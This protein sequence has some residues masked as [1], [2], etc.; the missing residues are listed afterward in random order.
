MLPGSWG[1]VPV[2]RNPGKHLGLAEETT[3]LDLLRKVSTRG[4][5]WPG[6][7]KSGDLCLDCCR[8]PIPDEWKEMDG[9][10]WWE[11][12]VGSFLSELITFL[13]S[14]WDLSSFFCYLSYIINAWTLETNHKHPLFA[15]LPY[16]A[17]V[18]AHLCTNSTREILSMCWY[19]CTSMCMW[20]VFVLWTCWH[21]CMWKYLE[22]TGIFITFECVWTGP[23]PLEKYCLSSLT[24]L[25]LLLFWSKKIK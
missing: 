23:A 8:D 7:G 4:G 12:M 21:V 22:P 20:A 14:N 1:G 5:K 25:S 10:W 2:A 3:S 13:K 15:I 9:Y 16:W 19:V 11:V 17:Q 6:R 24:F 18:P